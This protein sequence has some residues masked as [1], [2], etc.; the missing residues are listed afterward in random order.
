MKRTRCVLLAQA[1]GPS[2]VH[3]ALALIVVLLGGLGAGCIHS[4]YRYGTGSVR[5]ITGAEQLRAV[6]AE[7]I[8][9]RNESLEISHAPPDEQPGFARY[10]E[11]TL[12][13][14]RR[15]V[16]EHLAHA[17]V[18]RPDAPVLPAPAT[19]ADVARAL[20][21]ARSRGAQSVVFVRLH[22]GDAPSGCGSTAVLSFFVGLLPWLIFDSLPLWRHG[23]V[24][25]F[26]VIV[27]S[28]DGELLGRATR[29]AA[30][31]EHLSAWGCGADG[32]LSDM[33]RRSLT[34]AL[35]DVVAQAGSGWPRRGGNA[36]EAI[37][38]RRT[39]FDGTRASG[40]GWTVSL[41]Q[42][43]ELQPSGTGTG[44]EAMFTRGV[45]EI[46]IAGGATNDAEPN[47]TSHALDA[48]RSSGALIS[49]QETT[50]SGHAARRAELTVDGKHTYMLV[51]AAEGA[52]F[53]V[54]CVAD[55]NTCHGVL[56]SFEL[57]ND[58]IADSRRGD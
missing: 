7:T 11:H 36:T 45:E 12:G 47:T 53:V 2:L 46:A 31:A 52:V 33:L 25:G 17:G 3:V 4:G 20:E 39:R 50:V 58:V 51:V 21:V 41:G 23:G 38:G 22:R 14:A 8:D 19:E 5:R 27:A 49:E 40:L 6:A 43:F 29:V 18:T 16:A 24:G 44:L 32:V 10:R 48:F 13:E 42:G 30:F 28:T 1:S 54:T 57:T 55:A 26:E 34:A 56:G 9:I 15:S 35:E 37:L